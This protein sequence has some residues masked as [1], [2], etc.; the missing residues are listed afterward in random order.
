METAPI[1]PR[2]LLVD[3]LPENWREIDVLINNAGLA[4][5]LDPIHESSFDHWEQ[6]IDTNLKGLLYITRLVSPGMAQRGRGHIINIG[7]VA[8]N[9]P[10]PGGNVYGAVQRLP[11]DPGFGRHGWGRGRGR[12]VHR[13]GAARRHIDGLR[14]RARSRARCR[15]RRVGRG[16]RG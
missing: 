10:Y 13:P 4:K 14:A 2:G 1:I 9:Y 5:G 6:M 15:R 11:A 12:I 7:S 3:E 8:G 16:R